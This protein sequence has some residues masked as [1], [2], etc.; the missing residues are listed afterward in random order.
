MEE[1]PFWIE[2]NGARVR[3]WTCTPDRLEALAAGRLLADGFLCGR[4]EIQALE[5]VGNAGAGFGAR[6]RLD[7]AC[8]ERALAERRHRKEHGCG[9][10]HYVACAPGLIQR[11]GAAAVAPPPEAFTGLFRA[12]F[13][14]A[15]RYREAGGMHSAALSDGVRLL[16]Q[17][18]DV[19]RHNAVDKAIGAALLAGERLER[20]GL[21]LTARVSAA[22]ALKGG[23]AGLAWIASRS[24]PTTLALRI[25]G[26]AGLPVVSRAAGKD[27]Q[28]HLP[29]LAVPSKLEGP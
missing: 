24:V 22:I 13:A 5:V 8:V 18:E 4:D 12:L 21:V 25:A 1:V 10:L 9:L 6:V 19:G 11:P 3:T 7:P 17:V 14:R 20:L 29:R 23:R 16:F 26:V 15:E 2:V 28:V 27:A